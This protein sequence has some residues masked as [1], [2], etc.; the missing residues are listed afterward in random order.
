MVVLEPQPGQQR[1]VPFE[2]LQ[3]DIAPICPPHIYQHVQVSHDLQVLL[4]IVLQPTLKHGTQVASSP[5]S[6]SPSPPTDTHTCVAFIVEEEGHNV[7][8]DLRHN[9]EGSSERVS[10]SGTR[11]IVLEGPVSEMVCVIYHADTAAAV[12][13]AHTTAPP[14]PAAAAAA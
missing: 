8:I 10:Q 11:D 5:P 14:P 3:K 9:K 6:C 1:H 12:A 2:I 13:T 7:W 4:H